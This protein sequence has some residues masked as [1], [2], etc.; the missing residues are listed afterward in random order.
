ME[1]TTLLVQQFTEI[2]R[3]GLLAG[4]IYTTVRTR[5]Q[6]GVLVPLLAGV[7]F[8]AFIIPS[9]MPMPGVSLWLAVATGLFVNTAIVAVYWLAWLAISN[10]RRS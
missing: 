3:L 9:T 6:T 8:V 4:L 10:S 2:F 1:I 5:Q 7:A